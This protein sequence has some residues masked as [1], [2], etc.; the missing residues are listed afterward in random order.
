ML[1]EVAKTIPGEILIGIPNRDFMLMFSDDDPDRVSAV[2]LQITRDVR[3]HAHG[4]SDKL[5]TLTD[6]EIR[7]YRGA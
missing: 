4:I 2:A 6:G 7:E 5:F 3:Q 1:A